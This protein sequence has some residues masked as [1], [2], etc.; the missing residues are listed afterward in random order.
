[1]YFFLFV[2]FFCFVD[3]TARFPRR[4][5]DVDRARSFSHALPSWG[6]RKRLVSVADDVMC[7]C[8]CVY[9]VHKRRA[10]VQMKGDMFVCVCAMAT[11]QEEDM[12]N[13]VR[14]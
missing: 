11:H 12:S 9:H 1:M 5:S 8:M 6:R 3:V 4:R 2:R 10:Y 14:V 13:K 7:T